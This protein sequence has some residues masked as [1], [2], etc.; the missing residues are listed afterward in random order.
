MREDFEGRAS[1]M[2]TRARK[3]IASRACS[4][5]RQLVILRDEQ[6]DSNGDGEAIYEGLGQ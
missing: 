2:V 6:E 4:D 1:M 5:G 3:R